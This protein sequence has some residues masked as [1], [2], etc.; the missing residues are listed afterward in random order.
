MQRKMVL[1]PQARCGMECEE[2][3]DAKS[4]GARPPP[5]VRVP[6]SSPFSRRALGRLFKFGP[7]QTHA[8]SQAADLTPKPQGLE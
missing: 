5:P 8:S 2:T 4:Q 6:F 1:R 3:G 7:R